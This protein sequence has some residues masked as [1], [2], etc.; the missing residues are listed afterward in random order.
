M[1][2]DVGLDRHALEASQ[3]G[4]ELADGAGIVFWRG[5]SEATH[6]IAKMRLGDLGSEPALRAMLNETRENAERSQMA[7]C[8]E[9][10]TELALLRGE[11][12]TCMDL[13][14]E[15]VALAEA[16]EMDELAARGRL[17]RGQ[18]LAERGERT[19]AAEQLA[20]AAATAEEIGR[21]RLARDATGALAA[22]TGG[23]DPGA[24]AATLAAQIAASARE[25]EQLMSPP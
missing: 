5:R 9:A 25:C 7:R 23:A 13:A 2:L 6:A 18:A 12:G 19:A 4:L 21:V 11:L 16:A 24:R 1:L 15:L 22:V 8:L 14:A 20:L 10:L 17:W 3:R